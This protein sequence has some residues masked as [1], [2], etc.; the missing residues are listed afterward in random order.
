MEIGSVYLLETIGSKYIFE[1][2]VWV[3]RDAENNTYNIPYYPFLDLIYK[4]GSKTPCRCIKLRRGMPD[5][6]I[7]LPSVYDEIYE[8]WFGEMLPA[9]APGSP[10]TSTTGAAEPASDES[11]DES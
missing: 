11:G 9:D 4:P 8:K 6:D 5:L 10:S 1:D 7:D 2:K 3:V